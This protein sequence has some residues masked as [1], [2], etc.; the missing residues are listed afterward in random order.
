MNDA[1]IIKGLL[2]PEKRILYT[3]PV[4][5]GENIL[6]LSPH[7]DDETLGCGG[8]ITKMISLN[9]NI[10][11][12]VMTDGKGGGK[13]KNISMIRKKEFLKAKSVLGY[14]DFCIWNYP[15]GELLLYK[16]ELIKKVKEKILES[17]PRIVLVPNLND[18]NIDHQ[19][20][21][22]VLAM[23]LKELENSNI[24]VGMYEIWT[25]IVYPNCY[26][27]ITKEY[28]NKYNAMK[29]Y[30]SQENYFG[31]ID[32]AKYLGMFRANLSMIYRADYME[33]FK[34]I[35]ASKYETLVKVW[36]MH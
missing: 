18:K 12:I 33:C 34:L 25:P 9:I 4:N 28:Q 11:V 27:D 6:I 1:R 7:M 2:M 13:C 30:Q 15:D 20:T 31:I 22:F 3:L 36:H 32:K 8:L 23:A 29:C 26:L 14:S 17:G 10:E 21:N 16:N 35:P 5:N 19:I 24:L